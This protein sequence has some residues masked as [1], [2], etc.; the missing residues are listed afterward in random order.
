M[1]NLSL[2]AHILIFILGLIAIICPWLGGGLTEGFAY[3]AILI[4]TA[5]GLL[6]FCAMLKLEKQELLIEKK[7]YPYI[8]LFLFI[9]AL[10]IS[11]IFSLRHY[12]SWSEA[13]MWLAGIAVFFVFSQIGNEK[14]SMIIC[15]LN[16]LMATAISLAGFVLFFISSSESDLRLDSF[17]YNP[18]LLAGYLIGLWPIAMSIIFSSQKKIILYILNIIIGTG[19]ILTVSYTGWVS[20]LPILFFWLIYFR[21][22]IFTKKGI[23]S[24][25]LAVI[26]IFSC[27]ASLRYFHTSS[28]E[29]G[30]SIQKTISSSHG[31]SSFAQRL[32]FL[33]AGRQV[34]LEDPWTGIGLGNMKLAY[35][36]IQDNIL[37]TPRSLHNNYFDLA[38]ETGI[39]GIIGWLGFILILLYKCNDYLK[40][41][42]NYYFFGLFMGWLGMLINGCFDFAWQIK[43]VVINFF[44]F[45][46]LL[47]GM[48]MKFVETM[49]AA[50]L[51]KRKLNIIIF[52]LILFS[53]LFLCRG[54]QI[55]I[56]QNNQTNGERYEE[57]QGYRKAIIAYQTAYKYN[58]NPALLSKIGI[59][60]YTKEEYASAEETAQNW[61][62][63]SPNDPAAYQLLGRIYKQ[64]NKLAE[65]KKQ[66]LKA[67]ALAPLVN[68]EIEQDLIEIYYL[69]KEYDILIENS[70]AYMNIYN[71][72]NRSGFNK[73]LTLNLAKILDYQGEAYLAL[74][75][76]EKACASWQQALVERPSYGMAQQKIDKYCDGGP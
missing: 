54:V 3:E 36:K 75:D 9:T 1:E 24:T 41:E 71:T 21:K 7:P 51:Q 5:L 62:K 59:L 6:I 4:L 55:F 66:F 28:I 20:F 11:S 19:F 14:V 29:Q 44:I 60:L 73:E 42:Q 40:K 13:V 46:G 39:I 52:I 53:L 50:S 65:A 76:K 45:S 61:I 23:L 43:I 12:N 27:T 18:N 15:W 33:E 35:Q 34:F 8:F 22:K 48:Y 72:K 69:L 74:D 31:A 57:L 67:H 58:K 32:Y 49:H 10:I 25:G 26:L 68:T 56:S 2:R 16:I 63:N 37:E 70:E 38:V 64:Q 17:L 47:Y 30:L